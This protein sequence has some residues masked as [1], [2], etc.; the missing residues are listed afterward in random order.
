M[1]GENRDGNRVAKVFC[2]VVAQVLAA[3]SD[4]CERAAAW[5]SP[6]NGPAISTSVYLAPSGP[7]RKQE[8]STTNRDLQEDA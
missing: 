6:T 7:P 8:T 2:T 1:L 4:K 3:V 5:N